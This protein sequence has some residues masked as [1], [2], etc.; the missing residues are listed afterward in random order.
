[1]ATALFCAAAARSGE[2]IN[3][4]GRDWIDASGV[5][6]LS[7]SAHETEILFVD[8]PSLSV[9]PGKIQVSSSTWEAGL[10]GAM[11]LKHWL[12]FRAGVDFER[13]HRN[14]L[15]VLFNGVPRF[16]WK[17]DVDLLAPYVGF[18]F[19][20]GSVTRPFKADPAENPDGW[21]WWPSLDLDLRQRR[22]RQFYEQS[23]SPETSEATE[24][25]E[26]GLRVRL[27]LPLGRSATLWGAFERPFGWS[28]SDGQAQGTPGLDLLFGNGR[29]LSMP[30]EEQALGL[31]LFLRPQHP[32]PAWTAHLGPGGQWRLD[33]SLRRRLGEWPDGMQVL[34]LVW[35]LEAAYALP[36][37]TEL[38]VGYQLIDDDRYYALLDGDTA[39]PLRH[40][41]TVRAAWSWGVNT[42]KPE[43][44][45]PAAPPS[46][47]NGA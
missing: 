41:V 40:S 30:A 31:R 39:T 17:E 2:A 32:G 6:K 46:K 10:H 28:Y 36:A 1:L 5:W 45:E 15:G 33:A 29:P 34:S 47:E 14:W 37:G 22:T 24:G 35:G 18:S 26:H 21:A 11:P 44:S 20:L 42:V 7:N 23:S 43:P 12:S 8:V 9:N 4:D 25:V 13:Q 27:T 19:Y 38:G 16:E 3:P